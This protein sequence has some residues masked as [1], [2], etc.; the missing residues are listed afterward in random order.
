M[1]RVLKISGLLAALLLASGQAWAAGLGKLSVTSMLGQPLRAEIELLS[2]QPDDLSNVEVKLASPEAY[3]L[4]HIERSSVLSDLSVSVDKRPDG[5]PVV[6]IQSNNPVDDPFVDLLIELN[7]SSGRIVREYTVLL[8]PSPVKKPGAQAILPPSAPALAKPAPAMPPAQ[9]PKA[10]AKPVPAQ[11]KSNAAGSYGPVKAGETLRSIAVHLAPPDVS[12]EMM[13]ASLYHANEGAFARNNMNLLKKGTVL[14]VPGRDSVMQMY[15]PSQAEQLIREQTT[16]WNEMRNRVASQTARTPAET[17]KTPSAESGKIVTAKPQATP[18][19][20]APSKDMLTL[21]KGEPVKAGGKESQAMEA[22]LTAKDHELKEAQT[23]INDLEKTIADLQKL[24]AMKQQQAVGAKPPAA[25]APA[26]APT[27]PP[28]AQKPL[29]KAP[30]PQPLAQEEPGF[31]ASLLENP[32]YIGGAIGAILLGGLLWIVTVGRRRRQGLSTFE[33]SVM[34][35][36]DQFKTSIFK[37]TGGAKT[38]KGLTTQTGTATD[39]SRLGLGAIDTHEVDPIAEAEVYMAYGRD[40]QAEEI[41]KE[42]LLKEPGRHEIA[43]KLLE[44]YAARKD[45]ANFETHASELYASLGNPDDPLWQKAAAL[46]RE[47]DP[48]NPLYQMFA[49]SGEAPKPAQATAV[50]E[51]SKPV[52]ELLPESV[53]E[54][55]VPMA[56]EAENVQG[57][58]P[59]EEVIGFEPPAEEAPEPASQENL[60]DLSLDLEKAYQTIPAFASEDLDFE[61][62]LSAGTPSYP[63]LAE[64]EE[65][66]QAIELPSFGNALEAELSDLTEAP[67]PIAEPAPLAEEKIGGHVEELGDLDLGSIGSLPEIEHEHEPAAAEAGLSLPDLDFSDIDLDLKEQPTAPVEVAAP[68]AAAVEAETHAI[69]PELLEEVNTKLDLAKAYMEMGDKEGAREILGEVL[70]EGDGQ[71]KQA[72]EDMMAEIG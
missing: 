43:V 13:M 25:A 44:I 36:G 4:Q 32:L 33:Q 60:D 63:T 64:H 39:F 2:V 11:Q 41:L 58:A 27:Q 29:A 16:A 22:E 12:A 20:T 14:K 17:A 56:S 53:M 18:K 66:E 31:F 15:S 68:A 45:K 59:V 65:T 69:D 34:S 3:M 46:G 24:A 19:P 49:A 7:W 62:E 10:E 1:K 6:R 55:A 30:M 35:G 8:D 37:T 67:A 54:A 72:A 47:L 57:A 50:P 21:S 48:E 28:A 40:A 38:E 9:A 5:K 70:K 61:P 42:A 71:Q 51:P 52:A 23:R 26:P